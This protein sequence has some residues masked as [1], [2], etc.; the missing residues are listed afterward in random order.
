M[1]VMASTPFAMSLMHRNPVF[2][3]YG[4]W[5]VVLAG[6]LVGAAKKNGR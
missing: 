1:L 4:Y 5:A 3:F 6:Q 2:V